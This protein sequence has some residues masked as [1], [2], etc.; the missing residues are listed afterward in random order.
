MT[1]YSCRVLTLVLCHSFNGQ[2][3]GAER[4]GQQ[5]LQG[6]DF[7]PSAFLDSLYDTRLKPTHILV[8]LAPVN[9]LPIHRDVGSCTSGNV[10][11][12]LLCCLSRLVKFSRKERPVGSQPAFAWGDVA[13][14]RNPYPSHYRAA[15]AF[16]NLLCPLRHP[17]SLRSGYHLSWG[18]TGLPS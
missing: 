10:C 9:G 18:A 1:I 3:F 2:C 14:W 4:A 15:F 17:L 7:A 12:H 13:E 16:S 11:C 8:G 6:F 5:T